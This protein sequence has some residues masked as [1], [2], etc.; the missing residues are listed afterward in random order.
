MG[1]RSRGGS[2]QGRDRT[3]G[4][5]IKEGVEVKEP[6]E[7]CTKLQVTKQPDTCIAEN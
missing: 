4:D 6:L 1:G 3:I 2:L 5:D 7:T